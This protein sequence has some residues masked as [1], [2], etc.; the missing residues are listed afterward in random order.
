MTLQRPPAPRTDDDELIEDALE[1]AREMLGMDAAYVADTRHGLLTFR[2]VSGDG[3]S[4]GARAG[5]AVPLDGTYCQRVL[6]GDLDGIVRDARRDP[7]VASMPATQEADIGAYLGIPLTLPDGTSYGTLCGLRHDAHILLGEVEADFL[8]VLGRLIVKQ[9]QRT[10]DARSEALK[11]ERVVPEPLKVHAARRTAERDRV[12]F[13]QAPF[14]SVIINREGRVYRVNHAM[15]AIVGQSVDELLGMEYSELLHADDREK[16][17]ESMR[18]MLQGGG[19]AT[20]HVDRRFLHRDGR[21][22]EARVA[23]NPI[24]DVDGRVEQLFAQVQDVTEARQT[25]R[26]LEH[27]QSEMVTRLAAAAEFRDDDTGDHTRRVGSLSAAMAERLGLPAEEVALIRLAAP[28]H[29]IGKIALPDAI[30]AT[31]GRLTPD[32]LAQMKTHTTSGAQMLSGS[33]FALVRMAEQIAATHHERWD[34]SGYPSALAG[35]AIPISGRIVAVAD[36]FDALT[37]ARPYKPAWSVEDALA[38]LQ[39]QSGR[40]FDPAVLEAFLEVHRTAED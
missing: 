27:A 22:V 40:H 18:V 5:E 1:A 26:E 17:A 35:E 19:A 33:T 10:K 14:G 29:D 36:V 24:Y 12:A 37:H 16:H 9:L 34:G 7:R 31:T 21:V 38:E 23:I 3:E 13:D 20:R 25:S 39:R 4:F 8:S 15:C 2:W 28:L 6:A 30:L 32:E 11:S